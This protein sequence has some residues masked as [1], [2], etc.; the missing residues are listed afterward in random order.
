MTTS[1][2]VCIRPSHC[3]CVWLFN[4][5][6]LEDIR[7]NR[8]MVSKGTIKTT[9]TLAV[10]RMG[11]RVPEDTAA[12]SRVSISRCLDNKT[13]VH[14][15]F[16]DNSPMASKACLVNKAMASKACQASRAMGS[17]ASVSRTMDSKT[18][19]NKACLG[20][21]AIISKACLGSKVIITKAFQVS[22]TSVS[23]ACLA[24]QG[25][26]RV[27]L[28]SKHLAKACMFRACQDSRASTKTNKECKV[29]LVS[30]VVHQQLWS[31]LNTAHSQNKYSS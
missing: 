26:D 9:Q 10:S 30:K 27:C 25:M 5:G 23:K 24:S 6:D 14:R 13:L 17:K 12:A 7:A 22:R 20:N 28:A 1:C 19:A 8:D 3:D 15:A 2:G 16:R 11:H 18:L 21:K 31:V 4:S 29:D